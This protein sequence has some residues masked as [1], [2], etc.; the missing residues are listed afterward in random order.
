MSK[1]EDKC[2]SE[3]KVLMGRPT[4]YSKELVEK[5]MT[6]ISTDGSGLKKLCRE[7][8][9]MPEH[10]TIYLWIARYPDFSDLYMQAKRLQAEVRAE[11]MVDISDDSNKDL[12]E[13]GRANHAAVQRDKLRVD[14]RK[15]VA[16][17]LL[18]KTYGTLKQLENEL[19]QS[20]EVIERANQRI[21]EL[22]KLNKLHEKEF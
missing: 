4:D 15:W 10:S 5:I 16:E 21:K 2:S 3:D 17:R 20:K 14:T 13:D 11:E 12:L 8:A 18:P 22:E 9:W 6:L 1:K 7:N 19:E